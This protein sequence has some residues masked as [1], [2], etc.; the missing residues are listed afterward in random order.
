MILT[1]TA[2]PSVDRTVEIPG[3]FSRGE[4]LRAR[5]VRSQPGGKGINVS[6]VVAGAGLDTLALLPARA[7]DRLLVELDAVHLNYQ[8]VPVDDEVRINLTIAEPDGMTTKINE[9]GAALRASVL[10]Q[11]TELIVAS[12]GD[13]QWVA[14]CGSLPPG[15]PAD[16]YATVAGRLQ[17]AGTHVAVDTSGPPLT[18]VVGARPALLKPNAFELAELT[19]DDGAA[20]EASAQ[21]GD[22]APATGAAR[23]LAERTGGAVL[24]T[25]GA[26]G[27]LLTV[28]SDTWFA[29]P[30]RIAVRSTV[31]AG[32]ASLAGYLIAQQRGDDPAQ[33]LRTAVAYGSA[34]ASL[35][36]TTPPTPGDL[37][38][39]GV[40]V[41]PV[42]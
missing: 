42:H 5:S 25:L 24:T 30:P 38:L 19:G 11:L 9:S 34:A 6:R 22:V 8:A 32:D 39:A 29:T 41:R 17:S 40:H 10:T 4:V 7:G 13:A 28:G 26:A 33:R 2:N 1:V 14:L 3:P 37:D 12:A 21:A 35:P 27:A 16:W 36:G 23:A 20:L 18:A 15:V 31:G